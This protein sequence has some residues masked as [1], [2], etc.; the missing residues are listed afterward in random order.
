MI[1][2]V[3]DFLLEPVIL[4][5]VIV[6]IGLVLQRKGF[7]VVVKGTLKAMI[8][9]MIISIGGNII[10][11]A[12]ASFGLM[13]QRGFHTTGLILSVEGISGIAVDRY[14][15]QIAVIMI[16]GMLVNLVLA[17]ITRFH[18]V[19]LTGQQ[20]LY[21]ASMIVVVLTSMNVHGIMVYV[22][23]SLALGISMVFSPAV[24]QSYTEKICK[25]DKIAVGHFGGMVYFLAAWLGK[26]YGENSKSAE[27]MK[28]PKKLAFLRDSSITVSVT[29]I[30]FY[31]VAVCASGRS[32][33]ESNLSDGKSYLTYAVL[34]ALTFTVGFVI[35]T[36]GIRWF[37]NEIVPAIK[38]IADTW[39]P[40]AKPAVDCPVV[41]TYAP[42]SLMVGFFASFV[43]GL[44]SMGVMIACQITVIIPG[45]MAHFFVGATAGVYGNSTGGR[46]GAVL[47]GFVAG[48]IM[49]VLPELFLPYIGQFATEHVTFP[50][51]DIGLV[52]LILGKY[53][54]RVGPWGMLTILIGI[55]I[56]IILIPEMLVNREEGEEWYQYGMKPEKNKKNK[57]RKNK[58]PQGKNK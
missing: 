7:E 2:I 39:I 12:V 57:P 23:G 11:E 35:I 41:F 19:F 42:N 34:Q 44:V 1:D 55:I 10:S 21:M 8:G 24:L 15:T 3:R 52:G 48:V 29:M 14:G 32:Y 54:K 45:I 5:G 16:L 46:R 25:T 26:I 6:F 13:I 53:I 17:R 27:D 18:Y 40:D 30:L 20:T 28:F 38:G 33:V 37:I 58:K 51:P 9:F 50:E 47:G 4:I 31:V 43:G 56:I 36:T 49:S 22:L